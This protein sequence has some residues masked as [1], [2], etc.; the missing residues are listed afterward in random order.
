MNQTTTDLLIPLGCKRF[1]KTLEGA[2]AFMVTPKLAVTLEELARIGGI[3]QHDCANAAVIHLLI[4]ENKLL[5]AVESAP[6]ANTIN[7]LR[8][9]EQARDNWLTWS[10]QI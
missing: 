3:H 4:K 5:Q 8:T 2:W 10:R 7:L 1:V 9:L 6:D